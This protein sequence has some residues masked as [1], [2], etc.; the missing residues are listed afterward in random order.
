[1]GSSVSAH[2]RLSA[3]PPVN[4][5][6]P[7]ERTPLVA[8][9]RAVAGNRW[10]VVLVLAPTFLIVAASVTARLL[11][12]NGVSDLAS[13]F[14][15]A[16]TPMGPS[17][18]LFGLVSEVMA[19]AERLVSGGASSAYNLPVDLGVVAVSTAASALLLA[20]VSPFLVV[21]STMVRAA[22]QGYRMPAGVAWKISHPFTG[23]VRGYA[24]ATTVGAAI[25]MTA[26]QLLYERVDTPTLD[27]AA[28]SHVAQPVAILVLSLIPIC[29]FALVLASAAAGFAK[30]WR[31]VRAIGLARACR[32]VGWLLLGWVAPIAFMTAALWWWLSLYLG[33]VANGPTPVGY[34]LAWVLSVP[35]YIL[36]G[37]A[38]LLA[39]AGLSAIIPPSAAGPLAPPEPRA[40]SQLPKEPFWYRV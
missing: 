3:K 21:V 6:E 38:S 34:L 17:T 32:G 18:P 36:P 10:T 28:L 19:S 23:P 40:D 35:L 27:H 20:L 26:A 29:Y 37:A 11:L 33:V 2:A 22:A 31:V 24:I 9:W 39:L 16:L 1:M 30:P 5:S 13:R 8:V 25:V 4:L 12:L 14:G 7:N 15:Y